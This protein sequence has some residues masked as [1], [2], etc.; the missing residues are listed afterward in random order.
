MHV[1]RR[2]ITITMSAEIAILV[3][4]RMAIEIF[5][6]AATNLITQ[7]FPRDKIEATRLKNCF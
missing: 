2:D 3:I 5:K 6:Q 1:H 7:K 4:E